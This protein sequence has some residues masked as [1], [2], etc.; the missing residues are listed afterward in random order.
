MA[1]PLTIEQIVLNHGIGVNISDADSLKG[2]GP[3]DFAKKAHTHSADDIQSG[4]MDPRRLPIATQQSAGVVAL[5]NATDSNSTTLAATPYAVN[6]VKNI[7]LSKAGAGH[8]HNPGDILGGTFNNILAAAGNS[9]YSTR[10]IR[11]IYLSTSGP[12]SSTGQ[13]GDIW[14]RYS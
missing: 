8:V 6:A 14:F 1:A 12:S 7:A 10:Q 13:N 5:S 4:I 2:H 3:E 9:N 11:N